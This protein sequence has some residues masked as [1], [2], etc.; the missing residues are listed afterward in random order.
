M[1]SS[2]VLAEAVVRGDTAMVLEVIEQNLPAVALYESLGFRT[3]RRL[4]GYDLPASA[5]PPSNP[6]DLDLTAASPAEVAAVI[7]TDGLP[8][9]PWQ[10]SAETIA[11]LDHPWTAVR[12]GASL[13][14]HSDSSA[15]TI[16]LRALVTTRAARRQGHA[17]RL[18]EALVRRYPGK[19]WRVSALVPAEASAV[20]LL[21][22]VGFLESA[23]SQLQMTKTL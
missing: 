1:R 23:L 16:T 8:D 13:A 9:L 14:L 6:P 4:V 5:R 15:E 7:R 17:R 12:A 2:H 10:L 22:N 21:R 19:S 3:Q 11:Q 20:L 18:L